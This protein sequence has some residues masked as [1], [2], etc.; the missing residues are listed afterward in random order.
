VRR[1][2]AEV[3]THLVRASFNGTPAL[4]ADLVEQV[5]GLIERRPGG[6]LTSPPSGSLLT[7]AEGP[8]TCN[9][10]APHRQG[11]GAVARDAT[12]RQFGATERSGQARIAV[13]NGEGWGG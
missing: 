6:D 12:D 4:K 10:P 8:A 11:G 2:S 1:D 13:G 3:P 7:E 5:V 9:G